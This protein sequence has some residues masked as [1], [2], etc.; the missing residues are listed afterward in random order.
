MATARSVPRATPRP[1]AERPATPTETPDPTTVAVG[2]EAGPTSDPTA[3]P[4][5]T[6]PSASPSDGP[7]SPEPSD[8]VV[9]FVPA[10]ATSLRAAVGPGSGGNAP[11]VPRDG[12][13]GGGGDAL[14]A[15]AAGV[16]LLT[17]GRPALPLGV[18][19]TLVTTSGIVGAT[20]AFGLF[21]KRR[22]EDDPP[23]ELLAQ[24]R[25]AR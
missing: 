2:S 13:G 12:S 16:D 6:P 4:T 19:T 18:V 25:P 24:P 14:A 8:D 15:L 1:T 5:D 17:S 10:G 23:D 20:L 22:R 9:A 21:G 3:Q 11:L 7:A